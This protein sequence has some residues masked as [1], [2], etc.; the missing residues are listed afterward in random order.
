MTC[1]RSDTLAAGGGYPAITVMV[2]VAANPQ[3]IVTNSVTVSGGGETNTANDT[4][5]DKTSTASA[6]DVGTLG[7][8]NVQDVQREIN[9]ALGSLSATDDLNHDGAVNAVDVQFVSNSALGLVC[10]GG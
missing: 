3:T 8:V 1:T 4:A 5:N 6:C 10:M 9:E 2:N 7:V